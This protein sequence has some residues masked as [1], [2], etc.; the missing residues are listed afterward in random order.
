[1]PVPV[2]K[3]QHY[4]N[5]FPMDRVIDEPRARWAIMD[6]TLTLP[7]VSTEEAA[8]IHSFLGYL[9]SRLHDL[10]KAGEHL[11]L[12]HQLAPLDPNVAV[13][14]GVHYSRIG[15]KSKA[16]V[17]L[18]DALE[19][20]SDKN[21]NASVKIL[22]NLA[23]NLASIGEETQVEAALLDAEDI[24]RKNPSQ[25]AT[26]GMGIAD[27]YAMLGYTRRAIEL[28]Y[29]VSRSE[30]PS[31]REQ[32]NEFCLTVSLPEDTSFRHLQK[33]LLAQSSY[34]KERERMKNAPQVIPSEEE[35]ERYEAHLLEVFEEMSP[36]REAANRSA[37]EDL[38][39]KSI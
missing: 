26:Y 2:T 1:M 7:K 30:Q 29:Y 37:M 28:F 18:L 5:Q 15:D 8:S 31:N 23:S 9:H 38:D 10:D 14:L 35:L 3:V 25:G 13:N 39:A 6:L 19:N 4:A 11:L 24:F 36:L 34:L 12:A 33:V 32:L 22:I 21:P 17:Q 16:I 20:V 27:A